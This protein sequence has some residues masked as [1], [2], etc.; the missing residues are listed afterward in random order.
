MVLALA[1]LAGGCGSDNVRSP[2]APDPVEPVVRAL[3]GI[4]IVNAPPTGL[5]VGYTVRLEVHGTY[6]DGTKR[7]E[8]AAWTSSVPGVASVDAGGAVRGH[9]AGVSTITATV[10][11]HRATVTIEVR[12]P[13]PDEIFWRQFA[14]NDYECRNSR[15]CEDAGFTYRDLEERVLWRL[16]TPSP[17]FFLVETSLDAALVDRIRETIPQ[18]VRQLTG[19]PY[20]GRIDAGPLDAQE[21]GGG[22][23]ITIEGVT[24]G[25]PPAAPACREIEIEASNCGRA[26]VGSLRGCIALNM[27]RRSCLTPSLIMHEIGHALGFY[28][29]PNPVDIMHPTGIADQRADFSPLE[30]HHGAFAYTQPRGATYSEIALGAFGPRPPLRAPSPFDHGGIVV[31]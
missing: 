21:R 12:T 6:S 8:A 15:A 25:E 22:G 20:T 10:G 7:I 3:V 16:P 13:G 11:D 30:Q 24:P 26:Y 23:Q 19:A 5:T 27:Q 4:E 2:T 9:A 29:T 1:V 28:H 31:D 14:F 18:A 17:D